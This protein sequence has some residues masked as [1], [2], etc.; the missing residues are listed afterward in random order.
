[1]GWVEDKLEH[2]SSVVALEGERTRI[3]MAAGLADT[4]RGLRIDGARYRPIVPNAV[5]D[6]AGGRL[7]GWSLRADGG[8][9]TVT[10]HDGYSADADTVATVA[11]AAGQSDT[12]TVMPAGVSYVDALYAEVTS[13]GAGVVAGALWIGAVD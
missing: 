1:M 2:L 7:V 6:N 9:V 12:V 4:L 8:D 10:L 5:N 3:E 11:L 13:T